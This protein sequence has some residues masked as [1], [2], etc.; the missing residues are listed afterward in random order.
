METKSGDFI[1]MRDAPLPLSIET[2][3]ETLETLEVNN[4]EELFA[5]MDGDL[6]AQSMSNM[7]TNDL[8]Q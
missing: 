6:L 5:K 7:E 8:Q 1:D 4:N 3:Y 2:P